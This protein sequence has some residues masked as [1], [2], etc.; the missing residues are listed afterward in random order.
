MTSRLLTSGTHEPGTWVLYLDTT[1][2]HSGL[3]MRFA[4]IS[5][6]AV[7][8][9]CTALS[10]CNR[11]TAAGSDKKGDGKD[12]DAQNAAVIPV[13][14]GLAARGAIAASYTGTASLEAD[15]EAQ[16]VAKTAGVLLK[17]H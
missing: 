8:A 11:G 16:V 6:L 3:S 15:R 4:R 5:L 13:E 12:K 7:L 14:I 2:L 1:P 9:M 10:A 17:L